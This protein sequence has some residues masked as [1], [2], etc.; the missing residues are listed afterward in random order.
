MALTTFTKKVENG[1]ETR[2]K[3]ENMNTWSF[4]SA[5]FGYAYVTA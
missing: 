5:T 2:Y 1:W 3:N 4:C